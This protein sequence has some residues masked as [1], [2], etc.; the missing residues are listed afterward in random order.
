M[1]RRAGASVSGHRRPLSGA[2]RRRSRQCVR[3]AAGGLHLG[4]G[5]DLI[6][7]RGGN[8]VLE[9][10]WPLDLSASFWRGR[11]GRGPR[12]C[13][14][15]AHDTAV[16]CHAGARRSGLVVAAAVAML[17]SAAASSWTL[18]ADGAWSN[19]NSVLGRRFVMASAPRIGPGRGGG[20]LLSAGLLVGLQSAR[21]SVRRTY[22]ATQEASSKLP[23]KGSRER[24]GRRDPQVPCPGS[25]PGPW[26]R[27]SRG[28]G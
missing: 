5:F 15:T 20:D 16:E 21:R 17:P 9:R 25:R 3:A 8:G 27:Y 26:G 19:L 23:A 18:P 2:K 14:S 24:C 12:S 7:S 11:P 13:A 1:E 10:H 28:R 6:S 4:T 22:T